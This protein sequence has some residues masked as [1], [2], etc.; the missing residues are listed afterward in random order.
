MGTTMTEAGCGSA[1]G[2][3]WGYVHRLS[4]G[5]DTS[6]CPLWVPILSSDEPPCTDLFR[7]SYSLSLAPDPLLAAAAAAAGGAGGSSGGSKPCSEVFLAVGLD[8][9]ITEFKRPRLNLNILLDVSS[10][11]PDAAADAACCPMPGPASCPAW[12]REQLSNLV[13]GTNC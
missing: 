2:G 4:V 10:P 6:L 8:S 3:H 11:W 13:R 12:L 5:T 7:P 1:W 9:G